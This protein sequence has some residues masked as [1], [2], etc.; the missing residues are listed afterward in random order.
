LAK[1]T[2]QVLWNVITVNLKGVARLLG[3]KSSAMPSLA[4]S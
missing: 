3:T 1:V 4:M 2:V